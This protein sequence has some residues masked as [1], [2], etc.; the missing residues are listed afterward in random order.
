MAHKGLSVRKIT[1]TFERFIVC[2]WKH[3]NFQFPLIFS[4]EYAILKQTQVGLQWK[5]TPHSLLSN[6]M[7]FHGNQM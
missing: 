5:L 7:N 2:M 1:I 4:S 6:R 3:L